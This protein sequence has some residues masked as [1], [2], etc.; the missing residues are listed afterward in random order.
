M[1]SRNL[2]LPFLLERV[3]KDFVSFQISTNG[4]LISTGAHE[5]F[6]AFQN[7][8]TQNKTVI[9][10]LPSKILRSFPQ[11]PVV[12]VFWPEFLSS[13]WCCSLCIPSFILFD[14]QHHTLGNP[15]RRGRGQAC[16]IFWAM[17]VYLTQQGS[18][19]SK[20]E[21]A[22]LAA[23]VSY[24]GSRV[25]RVGKN[26]WGDSSLLRLWDSCSTCLTGFFWESSLSIYCLLEAYLLSERW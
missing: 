26:C 10:R 11:S 17:S 6:P 2:V 21:V 7:Q 3:G 12:F 9:M 24:G 8:Y 4:L 20:M 13:H 22:C 14:S 5:E 1:A 19:P 18:L 16:D 23:A 25:E 15:A